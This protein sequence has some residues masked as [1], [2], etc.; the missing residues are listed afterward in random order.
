MP[1]IEK[2]PRRMAKGLR[3]GIEPA[4]ALT[5]NDEVAVHDVQSAIHLVAVKPVFG[6]RRSCRGCAAAVRAARGSDGPPL[7]RVLR[8]GRSARRWCRHP[9]GTARHSAAFA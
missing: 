5:D 4:D 1:P 3:V 2:T 7:G 8:G 6:T 9:R